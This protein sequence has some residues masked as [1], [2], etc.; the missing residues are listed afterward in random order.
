[1][2]SRP[3]TAAIGSLLLG[4]AGQVAYHLLAQA[5]TARAPWGITTAVSCLPVLIL[6]MGAAFAH[7]LRADTQ[8]GVLVPQVAVGFAPSR[9]P[10]VAV[11]TCRESQSPGSGWT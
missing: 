2:E 10:R 8:G 11:L 3:P 9:G 5:G 7:V 1:M 6:G 4:M